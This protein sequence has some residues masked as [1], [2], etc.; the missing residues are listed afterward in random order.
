MME[1]VDAGSPCWSTLSGTARACRPLPKMELP[2]RSSLA[3]QVTDILRRKLK[4]GEWKDSLPG[5]IPL[6]DLLQISRP[7]LRVALEM[8]RREGLI[9]VSQGRRR[10]ITSKVRKLL[11]RAPSRV[12]GF[13]SSIS[14]HEM[15]SFTIF[16]ISEL[17][18]RLQDTGY[19]LEVYTNPRLLQAPSFKGLESLLHQAQASCWVLHRLNAPIQRW[20]DERGI[21][22]IVMGSTLPGIRFPSIDIHQEAVC[23]HAVGMFL[24]LGHLRIALLVQESGLVGDIASEKG[25]LAG[26]HLSARPEVLPLVIRHDG[27][28]RSIQTYLTRLLRSPKRP[29]ALL[30]SDPVHMLT[31][32][33]H[34]LNSG[35]RVPG[36][37]SLICCGEEAYFSWITPSIA[38]YTVNRSVHANRLTRMVLHLASTGVLANQRI[39]IIPQFRKG[40]TLG[41]APKRPGS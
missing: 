8:L 30:V 13:L 19:R 6:C 25:F 28:M 21:R 14:L 38:C 32:I 26:C 18:R 22:A 3:S 5:E 34:L 39:Q 31:A 41:N 27:T 12:V 23:R 17:R 37:I 29:T 16:R 2:H 11:R 1:G 20:L 40:E 10:R 35:L 36:D 24:G 9:K 4:S 33:S 7:T 15:S